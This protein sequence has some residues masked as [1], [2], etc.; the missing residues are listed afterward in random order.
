LKRTSIAIVCS[1]VLSAAAVS[2]TSLHPVQSAAAQTL[3]V[4]ANW[5][6]VEA[7]SARV[8]GVLGRTAGGIDYGSFQ[9]VSALDVDARTLR[10]AGIG[11]TQVA[12]PFVL[13]LGGQRFD[14][15]QSPVPGSAGGAAADTGPDWRIVQFHG[16]VKAEWLD[17]LRE[18]GAIP[19]QYV[20]PF[21]YVVWSD[22]ATLARAANRA[23]VRWSGD[24]LPE[25][26]VL[27]HHRG[28]DATLRPTMALIS[29][30]RD[31]QSLS[32]ALLARG[33]I[34]HTVT[35]VDANFSVAYFDAPGDSLMELAR[36]PG[37][38]TIQRIAGGA[39]PRGEMSNQS[40]V[41]G[42][43]V[44]PS[45]TVV[46]GY[47][48]WLTSAGYDGAGVIVGVVDGGIRTTHVDLV[49]NISPCVS[50]GGSPTTCTSSANS[51]GTHV[52]GAIAGTGA[53]GTLLNGFLRGQG[54]A[55]GAKVIQ[56]RY[57]GFTSGSSAT[58]FMIPNG[59][60]TIYKESSLSNAVLT[61]NS[62]G[63]T[64]TPQGYDIP[65]QQVDIVARD[66]NPDIAGNQQILNVWSIMNGNGDS[67]GACAPSS[68]ASPDEAKNLFAVGSTKMQSSAGAQS[69]SIFDVSSNSAHG[70][71]CDGR[72]RP[73]IVAP[74]CYT[75]STGSGTNTSFGFNCGTS[76]AS[77][78]VSG[79][80]A[81]FVEQY[82]AQNAGATPSPALVK[83]MFT[84]AA[85]NLIGFRDADNRVMGHRPDRF[86]GYG[87]LD[88][89]AVVNTPDSVFHIDQT[90]VLTATGQTWTQTLAAADPARPMRIMLAWT[91]AKGHGL[92]GTTPA[93]VNDLDLSVVA[94]TD[95]Y[96]GNAVGG[97]GWSLSGGT[98]DNRNNL[99]GIYLRPDQHNGSVTIEVLAANLAADALNPI[100]PVAPSQ[101]FALVC[102]NC[103]PAA[104]GSADLGLSLTS[105][106]NPVQPGETL[107]FVASVVNFGADAAS[108]VVV[109]LDLPPELQF[110]SGRQIEG[111]GTW[112]C[113]AAG[114]MVTCALA[115]GTIAP[116]S[117]ANVLEIVTEVD[118]LFTGSSLETTAEVN[119]PLFTDA[120]PA[121]NS[122]TV[123][124]A[125]GD[126]LFTDGFDCPPDA[127]GGGGCVP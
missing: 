25:F 68:L 35:P 26:R 96:R 2:T 32:D 109:T 49:D 126:A 38:Y 47:L 85:T 78:V 76:M 83:A 77:P 34:L 54:V 23:E 53:T 123:V 110:V 28:G 27:P 69:N 98:A 42:Y 93:W 21:A 1:L 89:D 8:A 91:D 18:S 10:E 30:H 37:I 67:G 115:G 103:S 22:G 80:V 113:A 55:P 101:D 12:D 64:G 90:E 94:G 57:S 114:Q 82:R 13:D 72:R 70:N 121:N 102:Y 17:A 51:H 117:F 86:Q 46:P 39:G 105:V 112:T 120:N 75:D 84:A 7:S 63:P 122:V 73:D 65:T 74:G 11:V 104:L 119:A 61:N 99:E 52:A 116:A 59:M 45:Y 41:G 3:D 88:L 87:R 66:A 62:W 127:R 24:F 125:V 92:G 108:G 100:T 16:P 29:P 48:S 50:A 107:T 4:S 9:W 124:S 44:G 71:A 58:G 33:G 20:H 31:S 111:S 95:T 43:G 97:D 56:Q 60:L 36:L 5:L 14:P 6:R 79:A 40:I 106:P 118:E 19:A 15:L 81:V